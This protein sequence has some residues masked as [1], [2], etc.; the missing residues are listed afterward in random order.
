[1]PD[2]EAKLFSD[3]QVGKD[4]HA[5]FLFFYFLVFVSK[6]YLTIGERGS[7]K[8]IF[9]IFEFSGSATKAL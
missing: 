8:S 9:L 3:R 1:M 4:R 7:V 6:N 2:I 5:P